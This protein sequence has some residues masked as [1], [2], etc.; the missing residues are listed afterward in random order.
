MYVR[1]SILELTQSEQDK[2]D[3]KLVRNEKYSGSCVNNFSS[4]TITK[5]MKRS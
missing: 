3:I 1:I 2:R 4:I 5:F